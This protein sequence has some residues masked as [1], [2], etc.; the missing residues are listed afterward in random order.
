MANQQHLKV[1]NASKKKSGSTYS[2]F[3]RKSQAPS[4][5][6]ASTSAVFANANAKKTPI[7]ILPILPDPQQYED[8]PEIA[9]LKLLKPKGDVS[10]KP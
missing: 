4:T 6:R 2:Y 8:A 10:N 1:G 7:P 9:N 3:S 5:T